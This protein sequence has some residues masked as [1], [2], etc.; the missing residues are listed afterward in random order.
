MTTEIRHQ[1]WHPPKFDRSD[2]MAMKAVATGTANEAQ[3]KQAIEYIVGTLGMTYDTSYWADS[4]RNSAFAEGRRFVGL[5]IVKMV[6]LT[7]EA[8]AR[9]DAAIAREQAPTVVRRSAGR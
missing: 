1:P 2:A 5:Q 8:L 6:N 9:L 3:Q 4:D 7:G